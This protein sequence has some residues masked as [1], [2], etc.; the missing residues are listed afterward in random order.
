MVLYPQGYAAANGPRRVCEALTHF[1]G[2]DLHRTFDLGRAN[3]DAALFHASKIRAFHNP[4]HSALCVLTKTADLSQIVETRCAYENAL[5]VARSGAWA[6]Y[7]DPET[8]PHFPTAAA[9]EGRLVGCFETGAIWQHERGGEFL[10]LCPRV[11]VL[12]LLPVR[13]EQ[14]AG[15]AGSGVRMRR[16]EH[17]PLGV[18]LQISA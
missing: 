17:S 11:E 12:E 7:W 4:H 15:P 9:R 18:P 13:V 8:D 6:L 10:V 2:G 16:L 14:V 1:C 5:T 3:L